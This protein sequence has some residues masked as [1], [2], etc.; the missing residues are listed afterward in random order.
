[1]TTRYTLDEFVEQTRQRDR[2]EGL[3]R[4]NQSRD[5][6][7]AGSVCPATSPILPPPPSLSVPRVV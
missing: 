2:G 6:N 3:F 7:G 1:M 4:K 5:S